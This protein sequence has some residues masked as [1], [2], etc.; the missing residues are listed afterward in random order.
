MTTEK[1]GMILKSVMPVLVEK[2]TREANPWR[3]RTRY[4]NGLEVFSNG[5]YTLAQAQQVAANIR[6]EHAQ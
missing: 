3:V 1:V 2:P 4:K 5:G 6:K